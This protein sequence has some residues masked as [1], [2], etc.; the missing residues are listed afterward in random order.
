[1]VSVRAQCERRDDRNIVH[2]TEASLVT[3]ENAAYF[4]LGKAEVSGRLE[5]AF[6]SK[7]TSHEHEFVGRLKFDSSREKYFISCLTETVPRRSTASTSVRTKTLDIFPVQP[8]T[9]AADKTQ[10]Q[11]EK[12]REPDPVSK[13]SR[14]YPIFCTNEADAV[15]TLHQMMLQ[16]KKC[17]VV[18]FKIH[19]NKELVVVKWDEVQHVH[20][21]TKEQCSIC[22]DYS[23]FDSIESLVTHHLE[24]GIIK[25][26]LKRLD[27]DTP[28]S[29]SSPDQAALVHANKPAD[30]EST[31]EKPSSVI[32][33]AKGRITC[34]KCNLV[35]GD[36]AA[37]ISHANETHAKVGETLYQCE[38]CLHRYKSKTT[39]KKHWRGHH[40]GKR[41]SY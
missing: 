30:G 8:G 2:F 16:S 22:E 37:A 21:A 17:E 29:A 32:S 15:R 11:R 10:V 28:A 27:D 20:Q 18:A 41:I 33:Y 9:S 6:C 4:E 23:N 38:L 24:H 1:M 25:I 7:K 19:V 39:Y 3:L 40:K 5:C 34:T 36:N 35:F 26:K 13:A 14:V 31:R 12:E